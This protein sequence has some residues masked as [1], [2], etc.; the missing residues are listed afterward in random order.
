MN[1]EAEM[2]ELMEAKWIGNSSFAAERTAD[3]AISDGLNSRILI[4]EI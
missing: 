2:P 3:A 4:S 1:S